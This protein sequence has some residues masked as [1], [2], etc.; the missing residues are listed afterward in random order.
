MAITPMRGAG[1]GL[2][3]SPGLYTP[4]FGPVFGNEIQ[5]TGGMTYLIPAGQWIITPGIYTFIQFLDPITGIWR[6]LPNAGNSPTVVSSDGVNMRLAN[7]TGF[8]VGAVVTN[9]GTGYT[10]VPTVTASTGNSTW[11][12]IVGGAITT[13]LT[14]TTAGVGYNYPPLVLIAPPPVGGVQATAIA[15]LSS[16]VPSF[17]VIDQGA[18]YTTAPA[19][20][21]IPDPREASASTPGPT[22]AAVV[23]SSLVAS[24]TAGGAQ[25]ISAVIC[26]SPGTTALASGTIPTLSF[27][28]GGGSSAAATTVMCASCTPASFTV[29]TGGAGFTSGAAFGMRTFGGKV[30]ASA[31]VLNP[32]IGANLFVPRPMQ[33]SGTCTTT[34]IVTA[35]VTAATVIDAGLVQAIPNTVVDNGGTAIP[36][37][38]PVTTVTLGISPTDTSLIQPF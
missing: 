15:T 2:P 33:I 34:T 13:T 11:K 5:L 26:T 4:T 14:I 32:S 10:S 22:T 18:G 17:T 29:T 36:T 27:T 24:G 3:F 31:S 12:A 35:S 7:L 21:V 38:L 9:S 1:V 19:V 16:G 8:A 23:T 37:A 25:T 6:N 30:T 20:Y 28:G